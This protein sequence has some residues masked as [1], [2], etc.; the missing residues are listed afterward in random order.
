[1]DAKTP[2]KQMFN[3]PI[4]TKIVRINPKTWHGGIALKVELIGCRELTTTV[5]KFLRKFASI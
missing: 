2:I 4:E 3:V 1:M 5:S